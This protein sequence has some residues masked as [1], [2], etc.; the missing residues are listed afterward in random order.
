MTI[1]HLVK[2][3]PVELE[4]ISEKVKEHLLSRL[5]ENIGSVRESAA[6]ALV[7]CVE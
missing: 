7:G 6:I 5:S 2:C 1:Q 4:S 3:Y